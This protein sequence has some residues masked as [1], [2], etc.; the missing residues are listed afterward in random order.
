[1]SHPE[2]VISTPVGNEDLTEELARAKRGVG[3]LTIGLGLAVLVAVAFVAGM[4]THS[5]FAGSG[6]SGQTAGRAGYAGGARAGG[7]G[8]G[9]TGQGGAGQGGFG[10][11]GTVGTVDHVDGNT[12]Y[13]KTQDGT[14]V[15]VS[16]S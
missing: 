10:R 4:W 11:G 15:K 7:Q 8:Q 16:T 14:V 12:V 1:M 3:K 9:G 5:A 6:G 13:V 2:Q